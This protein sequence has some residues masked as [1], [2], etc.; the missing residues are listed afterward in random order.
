LHTSDFAIHRSWTGA[1]IDYRFVKIAAASAAAESFSVIIRLTSLRAE[2]PPAE[3]IYP[4]R[5]QPPNFG[6]VSCYGG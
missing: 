4:R 3:V 1:R 5:K 6:C 2:E